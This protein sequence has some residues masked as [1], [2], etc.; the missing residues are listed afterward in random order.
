MIAMGFP[1]STTLQHLQ[2]VQAELAEL[3]RE[4]ERLAALAYRDPL[5]GLRNRRYFSERFAEEVCRAHRRHTV[6]SVICVDINDFKHLNDTQG[7]A[8]GDEALCAVA[9]YLESMTRTED[10][11]CRIGGDEFAVLLPDTDA[12]QCQAVM[13]R[14][15][16]HLGVLHT[17]GLYQGLSVGA[18][19]WQPGDDEIRLLARADDQMYADKRARRRGKP[20]A[21]EGGR[22][23]AA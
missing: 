15:R 2:A 22:A 12:A 8:A 23:R 9:R 1:E 6:M 17:H 11:C 18:A 13:Q 16:N 10:C 14:L 20:Y 4:N 3:R 5:T 21:V 19:S 7:H